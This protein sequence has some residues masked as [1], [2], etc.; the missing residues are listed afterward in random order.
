MSITGLK[1]N[2]HEEQKDFEAWMENSSHRTEEYIHKQLSNVSTGLKL[3]L[4]HAHK[5][6]ETYL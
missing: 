1:L 2:L 5:N 4:C 6:L 3:N